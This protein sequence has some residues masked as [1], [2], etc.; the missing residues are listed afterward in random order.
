[1]VEFFLDKLLEF[2]TADLAYFKTKIPIFDEV[3]AILIAV[4]WALL[5]GNL[6]FQAVRSMMSG[7]DIEGEEPHT[8]FTRTFLFSFLLVGSRPICETGLTMTRTV[9]EMLKVPDAVT[10]TPL[11]EQSLGALP[12]AGWLVVIL[13]NLVI[14]WQVFRLCL[15]VAERYVV[16]VML[17]LCA[18]LA[19]GCGGSKSTHDIFAGW[20]RMFASMCILM[21]LN[22]IF[23]KFIL[24]ALAV[25]ANGAAIIPWSMLIVGI[26]KT[27]RHLD[28]IITRIGLNPALTGDPLGSR[29]PGFLTMAVMRSIGGA[30]HRSAAA[31]RS[32]SGSSYGAS[33]GTSARQTTYGRP[34]PA[35]A[36]TSAG[37]QQSSGQA[38]NAARTT[39]STAGSSPPDQKGQP[40]KGR[41][42]RDEGRN[43][44]AASQKPAVGQQ[45][46][47][48]TSSTQASAH[49][50]DT[51]EATF[52]TMQAEN[53]ARQV[54]PIPPN[55]PHPVPPPMEAIPS[56][57]RGQAPS[58]M[59]SALQKPKTERFTAASTQNVPAQGVESAVSTAVN[60]TT[61]QPPE[62]RSAAT[63]SYPAE[64]VQT[65]PNAPAS[66]QG[67]NAAMHTATAPNP[68]A[69][70]PKEPRPAVVP[71]DPAAPAQP[72]QPA[73]IPPDPAVAQPVARSV[74]K[75]V[76]NPA[77]ASNGNTPSVQTQPN[78]ASARSY[79][80]GAAQHGGRSD[81]SP[82]R[83]AASTAAA[84][85]ERPTVS[86]A[87]P[88]VTGTAGQPLTGRLSGH[89]QLS[90]VLATP[91]GTS[92]SV[93]GKTQTPNAQAAN[94]QPV[95]A[96]PVAQRPV[97][98][99]SSQTRAAES[100]DAPPQRPPMQGSRPQKRDVDKPKGAVS[101]EQQLR[102]QTAQP[103]ADAPS[104]P[105]HTAPHEVRASP[106]QTLKHTDT[107]SQKAAVPEV[108]A[109]KPSAG[110]PPDIED[111]ETW[112]LMPP[113]YRES[114]ARR[115]PVR[116]PKTKFREMPRYENG[117][118]PAVKRP[119]K[120]RK[121]GGKRNV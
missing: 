76:P 48:T 12:N 82:T 61:A 30:V 99:A 74:G 21:P 101:P 47:K 94:P 104:T 53:T 5:M 37:R 105:E 7:I 86:P 102:P 15:E 58:A 18:P 72:V 57:A 80:T 119:P 44:P 69:A 100:T 32:G 120:N 10:F 114:A 64:P 51:N 38:S 28:S 17:V 106:A 107:S 24:S 78:P 118:R 62:P 88:G 50:S 29:L 54:S 113:H 70:L 31:A 40:Q 16:L 46:N 112:E 92:V 83:P 93:P 97:R 1:M 41:T 63:P 85:P 89:P 77:D 108:Q 60:R 79:E 35:F 25:S 103:A 81:T 109:A 20:A 13:L 4:G 71:L 22:L 23:L 2:F 6:V 91:P 98:T 59:P 27:A 87:A 9:M 42:T 66:G 115:Q 56:P 8:L 55:P 65:A 43:T 73:A 90:P 117:E 34:Q 68:T 11:N 110:Q 67:D 116:P 33:R 111:V 36:G 19:F 49:S 95:T 75:V 52:H 84:A 26:A 121:K 45:H 96:A 14:F 3:A 39:E